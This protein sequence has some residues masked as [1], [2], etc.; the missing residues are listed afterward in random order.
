VIRK[1]WEFRDFGLSDGGVV[2]LG[3]DILDVAAQ[4][5]GWGYDE[6]CASRTTKECAVDEW[7]RWRGEFE[8]TDDLVFGIL[9][10]KRMVSANGGDRKCGGWDPTVYKIRGMRWKV[11]EGG[12]IDG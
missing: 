4:P 8:S 11:A 7:W 2:L 12:E 1:Q 9:W 5:G 6:G 10:W 3:F